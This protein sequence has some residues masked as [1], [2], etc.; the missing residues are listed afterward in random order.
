MSSRSAMAV[1][2]RPH[3]FLDASAQHRPWNCFIRAPAGTQCRCIN[4]SEAAQLSGQQSVYEYTTRRATL[5]AVGISPYLAGVHPVWAEPSSAV[6]T[7]SSAAEGVAGSS[8][9]GDANS[10]QVPSVSQQ[11]QQKQ[12]APPDGS[13]QGSSLSDSVEQADRDDSPIGSIEEEG[14]SGSDSDSSS[15]SD[16]ESS[17]DDEPGECK[18][19]VLQAAGWQSL[20][21]KAAY[22]TIA[23]NLRELM[24]ANVDTLCKCD[25]CLTTGNS[26]SSSW[27]DSTLTESGV[28][29]AWQ[30][31]KH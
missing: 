8:A 31:C 18:V 6:D 5:I 28:R 21:G 27:L 29:T 14:S 16:S 22:A 19:L 23:V 24:S 15:D 17:S 1:K 2:Y 20:W 3:G 26:K 4:G 30:Q 12:A 11:Q 25:P 13:Q 9:A 10:D 7:A